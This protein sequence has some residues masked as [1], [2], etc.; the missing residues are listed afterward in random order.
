MNNTKIYRPNLTLIGLP[1]LIIFISVFGLYYFFPTIIDICKQIPH[2]TEDH[3][4]ALIAYSIPVTL[5]TVFLYYGVYLFN[6][7]YIIIFLEDNNV[8]IKHITSITVYYG[9]KRNLKFSKSNT[10]FITNNPNVEFN[11]YYNFQP[12]NLNWLKNW[13]II[14]TPNKKT[15]TLLSFGYDKFP[16][17]RQ[18]L[19]D[20]NNYA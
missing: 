11:S 14:E 9:P 8:K 19:L 2:L 18:K 5:M 12:I 10:Q 15:I 7:I 6:K 17:L 16:S 13:L 1:I 20:N 3:I 4:A